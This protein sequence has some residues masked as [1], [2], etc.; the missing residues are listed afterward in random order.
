MLKQRKPLLAA[1]AGSWSRPVTRRLL[2][3]LLAALA[4]LATGC[5]HADEG[6]S[7]LAGTDWRLTGWSA[8]SLDPARFTITIGF[9]DSRF[10]GNSAVNSY[11][12]RYA[13]SAGGDF[14]IGE[15]QS[16]LRAGTPA[17]MQAEQ[18]YFELLAQSRKY[19][20]N[21]TT[22]ALNDDG[23]DPLLVFTKR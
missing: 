17:M 21:D 16:T 3:S 4:I 12:G 23:N 1:L 20:V 5:E 2:M 13:A 6:S 14:S 10:F 18:V 19:A 8:P 15:M 7:V 22:L 9:D 11:G